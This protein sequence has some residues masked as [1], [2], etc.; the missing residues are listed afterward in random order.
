MSD[1]W[2]SAERQAS[3]V[4]SSGDAV[5]DISYANQIDRIHA[6]CRVNL[7]EI[8]QTSIIPTLLERSRRSEAD[9]SAGCLGSPGA[10]RRSGKRALLK[11]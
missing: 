5:D 6:C 1:R 11:F 4:G 7:L 8:L 3:K 2:Q 10:Q 9:L